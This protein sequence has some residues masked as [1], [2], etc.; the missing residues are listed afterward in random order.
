MRI[1]LSQKNF[2]LRALSHIR[3]LIMM[4]RESFAH[5]IVN[6]IKKKNRKQFKK[7][8]ALD[9]RIFYFILWVNDNISDN[10]LF[11]WSQDIQLLIDNFNHKQPKSIVSKICN[12]GTDFKHV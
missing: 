5:R 1:V 6:K 4:E 9:K 3:Q 2:I 8:M 10:D 7:L 12:T 11:L